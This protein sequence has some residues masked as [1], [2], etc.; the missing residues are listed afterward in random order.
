VRI[1]AP[2]LESLDL[3]PHCSPFSDPWMSEL[4]DRRSKLELGMQYTAVAVYLQKLIDYFASHQLPLP[5][6]YQRRSEEIQLANQ[7]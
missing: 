4:D 1:P 3:I 6:G 7:M 2:V 5:D